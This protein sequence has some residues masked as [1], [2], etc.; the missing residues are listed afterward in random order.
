MTKKSDFQA[1]FEREF[2][3]Y[4]ARPG[5]TEQGFFQHVRELA[6][7]NPDLLEQMARDAF[8]SMLREMMH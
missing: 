7:N 4:M 8:D 5:A 1:W 6:K 2:E 3:T